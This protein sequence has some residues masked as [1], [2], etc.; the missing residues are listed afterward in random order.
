MVDILRPDPDGAAEEAEYWRL[1]GQVCRM[2]RDTLMN[3][4]PLVTDEYHRMC[5]RMTYLRDKWKLGW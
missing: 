4:E 5:D 1:W 2:T 3:G